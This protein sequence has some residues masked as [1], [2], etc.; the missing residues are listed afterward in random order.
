MPLLA[1][2]GGVDLPRAAKLK[3]LA[4]QFDSTSS[5]EDRP[6]AEIY[7]ELEDFAEA[8]DYDGLLRLADKNPSMKNTLYWRAF[9]LA[10]TTGDLE[11]GQ[12]I[13]AAFDGSPEDK[14][15]M[16][17]QIERAK[18]AA[19]LSEAEIEEIQRQLAM[20]TDIRKRADYLFE[21]ALRIGVNNRALALK[22]L[23]QLTEMVETHKHGSERTEILIAMAVVYCMEKSDRGFTIMESQMPKL[24]ELIDA[25]VKLDGFDTHYVRDGEWNMSASGNLGQL[26][27]WLSS[28]APHFAWCDF[29]R[30]VNLAGQF[31]RTEIRM[32]AQLKLAQG[33]LAGPPN[34]I[35]HNWGRF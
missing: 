4:P 26:L 12:K 16:L 24:N 33:I 23:D 13:A 3:H 28:N 8:R 7:A 10:R 2:L 17:T 35:R 22:L 31:E 1:L 14:Q 32:M 6:W 19:K 21:S 15:R 30:A 5:R 9:N 34:R 27:T 20:L 11:R 25:A 18:D 29:D